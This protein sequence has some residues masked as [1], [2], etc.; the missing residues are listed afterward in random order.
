VS[1][2]LD[3]AHHLVQAYAG[4]AEALAPRMG[5]NATTLRHEVN[6][7][8]QAKL[9]LADAVSMSVLA[10]DLRVLNAFA[11]E[12]G[13]LVARLP[14][15]MGGDDTAMHRVADLAREFGEVVATVTSA[16]ADGQISANE[17]ATIERNWAELT[18]AGQALMAHLR[19]RHEAARPAGGDA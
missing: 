6:R 7:T 9:G 8:G 18:A 17:L 15:S 13:C 11:A 10:N 5:K 16:T 12:C 2:V 3:A 14:A 1:A 4:G 19:A